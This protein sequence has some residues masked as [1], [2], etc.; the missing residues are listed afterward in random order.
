MTGDDHAPGTIIEFVAV[1]KSV[2]VTAFDPQ[3]MR[4][5]SI[6]GSTRTPRDYLA[7]L[8]IRKLQ[9]VMNKDK[10]E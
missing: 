7:K 3:H 6:V 5:V 9:Y 4:E 2:K 1:G 8:A 10:G